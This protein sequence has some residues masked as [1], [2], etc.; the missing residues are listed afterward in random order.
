MARHR[1]EADALRSWVRLYAALLIVAALVTVCVAY[2]LPIAN[3]IIR[4]AVSAALF[5]PVYAVV[6]GRSHIDKVK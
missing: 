6:T 5:V 3:G 2:F 1:A 4:L